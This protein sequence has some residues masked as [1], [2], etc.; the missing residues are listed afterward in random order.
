MQKG[1]CQ[2]EKV[3]PTARCRAIACALVVLVLQGGNATAVETIGGKPDTAYLAA[4]AAMEARAEAIARGEADE[5]VW[6][7]EHPALYTAGRSADPRHLLV[8]DRFPV[9]ASDRGGKTGRAASAVTAAAASA[10]PTGIHLFIQLT[11]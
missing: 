11:I 5:L 3:A 6:L 2:G 9:F 7:L 8:P 1:D 10:P 4:I